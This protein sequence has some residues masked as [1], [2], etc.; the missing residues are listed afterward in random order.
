MIRDGIR[1]FGSDA[2]ALVRLL[3]IHGKGTRFPQDTYATLKYV[4]GKKFDDPVAQEYRSTFTNTMVEDAQRGVVAFKQ[5]DATTWSVE[6]L[7]AM[8]LAHAKSQAETYGQE[9]VTG[10]VI[11]VPPY[12]G[13]FE[14]RVILDAAEIAGISVL[15]LM[16]DETAGALICNCLTLNSGHEFCNW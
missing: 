2:V 5:D 8:Q 6:A 12:F 4:I 9:P 14:R 7:I 11:T 10:A 13:H 1:Y 16:N 3:Q 15:S